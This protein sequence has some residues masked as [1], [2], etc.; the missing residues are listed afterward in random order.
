MFS[1]FIGICS[2]W[3]S[4]VITHYQKRQATHWPIDSPNILVHSDMR[5]LPI[6][7]QL[8]SYADAYRNASTVLCKK[9][10]DDANICTWPNGAVVLMLAAHAVELFLKGILL[11][12]NPTTDVWSHGHSIDSLSA[13]YRSQFPNPSFSW[14]IPFACSATEADWAKV[15]QGMDPSLS[16]DEIKQLKLVSP[17]P[18]I[19]YRYPM[20]RGGSDWPGLYG[21]EPHSF[22][23]VLSQ[24]KSDFDRIKSQLA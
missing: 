17:A 14:D 9:M 16:K 2:M 11:K 22:L 12:R 5:E 8:L 7:D 1:K 10:I 23:L 19:C 3:A 21:F 18:S 24:V 15:M 6:P 13:E 20:D 4:S